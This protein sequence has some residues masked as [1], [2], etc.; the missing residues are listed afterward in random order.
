MQNKKK[1]T[2]HLLCNQNSFL[3]KILLMNGRGERQN[4]NSHNLINSASPWLAV[5]G[6][7]SGERQGE[8]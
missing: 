8:I 2:S 3:L 1:V 7:R 5:S 6:H 4:I